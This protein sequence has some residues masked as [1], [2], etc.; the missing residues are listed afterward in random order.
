MPPRR[1]RGEDGDG[2]KWWYYIVAGVLIAAFSAWQIIDGEPI[3]RIGGRRGGPIGGFILAALCIAIG[4]FS[5]P[6]SERGD[7]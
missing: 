5:R 4:L 2:W 7:Q 6:S 1:H 3:L